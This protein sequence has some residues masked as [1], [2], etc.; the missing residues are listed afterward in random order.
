MDTKSTKFKYSL[1]T[2]GLCLLLS[3]LMFFS[4]AY[5]TVIIITATQ[6]YGF[7]EYFTDSIPAFY[8]TYGFRNQ[9][10]SDNFRANQLVASDKAVIEDAFDSNEKSIIDKAVNDYLYRKAEIIKNEL[11]YAVDN[12]DDSYFNYEYTADTVIIPEVEEVSGEV[13]TFKS[14]D[15]P[16][17]IEAAQRILESCKGLEF[18]D[19]ATLVRTDAFTDTEYNYSTDLHIPSSDAYEYI[20][21]AFYN[22]SGYNLNE[23]EIKKLFLEQYNSAKSNATSGAEAEIEF[24]LS[25]L[26]RLTAFK[27]YI[28]DRQGNIYTNIKDTTPEKFRNEA[29]DNEVYIL[30]NN[31]LTLSGLDTAASDYYKLTFDGESGY[32]YYIFID[33]EDINSYCNDNYG[34]LRYAYDNYLS[35]HLKIQ[36]AT[37]FI[38]L[39]ISIIMLIA[40]I[41]LCGHKNGEEK[42]STALTDKI[43]TDLHFI[44]S[45]V[46]TVGSAVFGVWLGSE[47]FDTTSKLSL[48]YMYAPAIIALIFTLSFM[49]LT[50]WLTSVARIRKAGEKYF[51]KMLIVRF[52]RYIVRSF[53]KLFNTLKILCFRPEKLDKRVVICLILYM[54]GNV[55]LMILAFCLGIFMYSAI[56]IFIYIWLA[57]IYNILSLCAAMYYI[58]NLDKIISASCRHESVN[59]GNKKVPESLRLLASNLT[60]TNE[61]LREAVEKAVKDEQMKTELITNVSHDLKT[62]LTSLISY[63]DLL[64]KCDIQDET[65]RKYIDVIHTQS[66]KLKRLIEDLIEAS[67]VSTGNVTLN[68]VRLN[69]SELAMQAIA[70]FAPEIEKNGNEIIFTAPDKA[71]EIYADGAKTYRILANLLNNAKK[72]SAPETRIYIS[73]SS[74][75]KSSFFEI[76]NISA[77]PLNIAPEELTERFVRGDKSRSKEGNGL[78]LS[79]AKDL[80]TLQNGELILAIDGDLF[81]ATVRLPSE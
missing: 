30:F 45:A 26:S 2:K 13:T 8:D 47:M 21:I 41:S 78:G 67:K 64:D 29:L 10:S 32:I 17:N 54:L 43:P 25:V 42:P 63:S 5:T 65:A 55:A 79:I 48:V 7:E 14:E 3:A 38:S 58:I 76:K 60:N 36:I 50:E 52:F 40:L 80:C 11:Q 75:G 9:F 18:L 68:R 59:F 31:T 28:T 44:L 19:Y 24:A 62:P 56:A 6:I 77:E 12:Y 70:E 35:P 73:V 27:F 71:P 61:A 33:N 46:I 53:K 81:K 57:A 16:R 72:Y 22:H 20:D 49:I 66:I 51:S 34:N 23:A 69:L 74:D 4:F 39:L 1:F 15:I 37:A